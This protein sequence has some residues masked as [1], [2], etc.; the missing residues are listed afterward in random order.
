M[1]V[2]NHKKYLPDELELRFKNYYDENLHHLYECLEP[3]RLQY[4]K[5]L[6]I[7]A[8]LFGFFG[9]IILGL[10]QNALEKQNYNIV[11]YLWGILFIFW[12]ILCLGAL[13]FWHN[14]KKDVKLLVMDK[15]V[16]FFGNIEACQQKQL[17]SLEDIQ[18]SDLFLD[19]GDASCDDSF[20]LH[21]GN[22]S[23][24]VAEQKLRT[25]KN[26]LKD[27]RQALVFHGVLVLA[28]FAKS[29]KGKIVA[30]DI[31]RTWVDWF[32]DI[33]MGVAFVLVFSVALFGALFNFSY[34]L[35]FVPIALAQIW[36]LYKIYRK[37]YKKVNLE[38]VIFAK[39]WRVKAT[40]QVEARYVLTPALMERI[41]SVKKMFD[42]QRVHFA[43]F[44][45]KLL[46][47]I[48]CDCDMFETSSLFSSAL[49]YRK[50]LDVIAQFY[51]IL[52]TID[53]LQQT[54]LSSPIKKKR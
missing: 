49:N 21:L 42:G 18:K 27:R 24:C 31:S 37:K 40:D 44:E 9:L 53:L 11:E 17:V 3:H 28:D 8:G 34:F 22:A 50:V 12:G 20:L 7:V 33:M 41:L 2:F 26:V 54:S 6:K 30:K 15:I 29:L 10:W 52:V 16:N 14:Y 4:L 46:I 32:C 45:N 35:S 47:A 5:N 23:V 39:N 1:L 25:S 43:F 19:V 36:C 13:V 48:D 38:D 51:S